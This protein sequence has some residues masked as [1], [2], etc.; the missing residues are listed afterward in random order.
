MKALAGCG[1]VLFVLMVIG[2]IGSLNRAENEEADALARD[3]AEL[4]QPAAKSAPSGTRTPARA[5]SARPATAPARGSLTVDRVWE[6]AG[7]DAGYAL[8]SYH[9]NSGTTFR[10]VV[11]VRCDAFGPGD[12]KIGTNTRSFFV[13]EIG[14]IAP[15]FQGTKQIPVSLNGAAFSS[16]SCVIE[17]AQ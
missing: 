7:A 2:M 9:N 5:Q 10:R 3:L 8:V 17:R 12:K 6:D 15:G 4:R 16:M 1:V 11:T 13:H 14:E